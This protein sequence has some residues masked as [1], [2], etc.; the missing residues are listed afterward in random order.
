MSG[1]IWTKFFWG[2]W[3]T[4]PALKLCSFAA[5][6]LWMRM[7]CIASAHDPIGYVA[8]AGRGLTE[9]DIARLTGASESEVA[10]LLG[11]LER[12]GVFSR[13]R[14][15]RIY[16]RRM[17]RDARKAATAKK[18]GKL[19][20]NPKLSEQTVITA[21]DNPPDK[22]VVKPQEPRAKSQSSSL[23]SEDTFDVFW[24]TYPKRE[25][26]NPKAPAQQ[27]YERALKVGTADEIL[28][29][30]KLYA[31]KHPTRTQYV[32]QAVTWLNQK[33]WRDELESAGPA[34]GARPAGWPSSLPDPE[35]VRTNWLRGSWPSM[36]G[37]RPDELG[38][39]IPAEI[40]DSWQEAA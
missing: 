18:N 11:E 19:G 32:A 37:P 24:K 31:A 20:G 2:D 21:S 25:G 7:L 39:L 9:T 36:W 5:Q 1:T 4:D 10:S 22:G 33:R 15:D 13:D 35:R 30:A 38:C 12:N 16:S 40:L 34:G 23:R 28:R 26:D 14:H 6:G 17:T 8:V 27:A 3:E 29:G